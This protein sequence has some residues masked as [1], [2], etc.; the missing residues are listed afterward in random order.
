MGWRYT[1]LAALVFG[2]LI[3]VLVLSPI[4]QDLEYHAFADTRRCGGIP[5]C[6]D[7]VSNLPFLFIGVWGLWCCL[8]GD[9][10]VARTAWIVLFAG[11]GIVSVGS[12]YYHWS[13]DN[14]SLVWD[15]LPM[16]AAFMGLFIALLG[17]YVHRKATSRLLFPAVLL[18]IASVLYW[19]W[20][21]DLRL[22]AWVQF[23]PLITL[24]VILALFRSGYTDQWLL[25]AALG[26]YALAKLAE[27]YDAAV[28][29][30][31]HG[32]LGGHTLKHL[33]IAV[34]CYSLLLM[35]R[36]RTRKSR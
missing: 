6:F 28:F 27:F 23:M 24:P 15:R 13:P 2:T 10:G 8:R 34:S 33:L 30:G 31:L 16:A 20:S 3:W 9:I 35:L 29:Q 25:A 1:V 19:H 12:A 22:Y 4:P 32:L 26:W 14:D 18:G 36:K 11:V 5:N 17:E 21:D 7:V